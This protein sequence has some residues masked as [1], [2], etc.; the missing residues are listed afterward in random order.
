MQLEKLK[1]RHG[2]SFLLKND[3]YIIRIGSPFA[4]GS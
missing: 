2:Q 4:Q 1:T 3:I